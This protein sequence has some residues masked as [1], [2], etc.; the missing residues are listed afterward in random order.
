MS[1][2]RLIV[3]A[4]ALVFWLGPAHAEVAP[5]P[6]IE[7]PASSE[8]LVLELT[9]TG[10]LITDPEQHPFI[11]IYGDGRVHVRR[12][13]FVVNNPGDHEAYLSHSDLGELLSLCASKG[14]MDFDSKAV[15]EDYDAA[16]RAKWSR[17]GSGAVDD[18]D[19]G[20]TVLSI[21]LSE[22]TPVGRDSSTQ[23]FHKRLLWRALP[24]AVSGYPEVEALAQFQAVVEFLEA[25]E[26]TVIETAKRGEVSIS[27]PDI[28]E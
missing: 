19:A 5:Q 11:R 4:L 17:T 22:Y 15:K 8:F 10:T 20:Y 16:V 13:S 3:L 21:W 23:N 24:L 6:H 14:L 25:I 12:P 1:L 9:G 7:Y 28:G 27:L 18:A 2:H 26:E